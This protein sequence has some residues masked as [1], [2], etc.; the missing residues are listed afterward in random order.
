M[1]QYPACL[2][3][4]LTLLIVLTGVS[5]SQAGLFGRWRTTY[6]YAAL[7]GSYTACG[8]RFGNRPAGNRAN[9]LHGS[10]ARDRRGCRYGAG[11]RSGLCASDGRFFRLEHLAAKF[12]GLRQVPAVFQLIGNGINSLMR[13]SAVWPWGG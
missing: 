8:E 13:P 7:P 1:A 9:C 2:R 6:N 3:T 5:A 4:L 12:M 11:H 10:E